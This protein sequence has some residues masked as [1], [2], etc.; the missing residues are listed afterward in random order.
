VDG[1]KTC[2]A[3]DVGKRDA[4]SQLEG[5]KQRLYAALL[6]QETMFAK[7]VLTY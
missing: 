6:N 5:S 1:D 7:I 4:N 2:I 3:S